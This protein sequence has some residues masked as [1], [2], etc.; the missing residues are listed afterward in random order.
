M[1]FYLITQRSSKGFGVG[2]PGL[3]HFYMLHHLITK[4]ICTTLKLGPQ[5]K[6]QWHSYNLL[7]IRPNAKG[8]SF[9]WPGP[10]TA[11]TLTIS[12][13]EYSISQP[14]HTYLYMALCQLLEYMSYK[15][16]HAS[17]PHVSLWMNIFWH[18]G[19]THLL[20]ASSQPP[21]TIPR[22][23]TLSSSPIAL[24]HYQKVQNS[25]LLES[26]SLSCWIA[27]R[28]LPRSPGKSVF[29]IACR[30]CSS[31]PANTW[32]PGGHKE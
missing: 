1:F 9:I 29:I 7:I 2:I 25:L 31:S 30:A 15:K 18:R 16:Q 32:S 20:R 23:H 24:S 14:P 26:W 22:A 6:L 19:S 17:L 4:Q 10:W 21:R 12:I 13:L 11:W 5:A 27:C 8:F 28:W 3:Q